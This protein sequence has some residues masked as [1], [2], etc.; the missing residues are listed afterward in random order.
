MKQTCEK[1]K[2]LNPKDPVETS[3]ESWIEDQIM[4]NPSNNQPEIGDGHQ[5]I[6]NNQVELVHEEKKPLK[7]IIMHSC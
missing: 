6:S 2:C 7:S 4:K 5:I 3:S 1:R